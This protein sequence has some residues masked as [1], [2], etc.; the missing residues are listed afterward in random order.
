MDNVYNLI[1]QVLGGSVIYGVPT[2][3]TGNT[4]V[5]L[6]MGESA[7]SRGYLGM[8]AV[9]AN[10]TV[11]VTVYSNDYSEGHTRFKDVKT[12]LSSIALAAKILHKQDKSSY[13][14]KD[15]KKYVFTAQYKIL[16]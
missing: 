13:Y 6:S 3:E 15:L 11:N 14:D 7:E 10:G 5:A 12:A 2:T 8:S 4:V 9:T 16:S 1:N